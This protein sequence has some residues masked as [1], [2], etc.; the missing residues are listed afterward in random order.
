MRS[1]AISILFAFHPQVLS[2]KSSQEALEITCPTACLLPPGQTASQVSRLSL[3]V[4][5]S[6]AQ[7]NRDCTRCAVYLLISHEPPA[8]PISW[9]PLTQLPSPDSWAKA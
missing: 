2:G 9:L 7:L 8:L 4:G 3:V 5:D 1:G 6:Q